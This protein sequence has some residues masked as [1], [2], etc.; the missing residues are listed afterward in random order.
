MEE[1]ISGKVVDIRYTSFD[2]EYTVATVRL[3]DKS[4]VVVTGP[5]A[6]VDI[7]D[8][9]EI[10]GEYVTH[11]IY[12]EQ[13]KVNSFIPLKP[14]D[15]QGIY[16]FLASGVIEGIGEKFA[17][18]IMQVFGDK[19]L[20][21]IE[22][23]PERL[24]EIEGIGSKKLDK[25]ITSYNEKMMLKNIII[26][27]AKYD[28]S[29]SLSIK[30]YNAYNENTLKILSNN[31]YR[32]C[33]DIKGIGFKKADEIAK[34]MGVAL[35]ST[36]R[37][38]QA[39]IYSLTQSTYEG[40]T[41]TTFFKLKSDMKELIDFDDED[42]ILS[43]SYDLYAKKQIIIDGIEKDDMKIF[44][45]RYALAET[46]VASKLIEL[47]T[48]QDK[49][50]DEKKLDEL[51]QEQ[52]KYSNIDFSQE[53]IKSVKMAVN[54]N[55]LIITGGPGTGKT[56]TLSFIIEI[57]ERIGKK[58]KLCAPTGKAS[59]RMA[60]ATN[61]DASTIHRLL[62]MNY[63][64]DDMQEHFL[65][66]EDE[67]IKADVIIVD[68]TS[69]V[70]I[71]LMQSLLLAI[72]NGT[73]LILVGDKDQ[74]PS[75]GAGNVLKDIINCEIIPCI[76]LNKI[77][78]QAMKSHIIV[79]AHR[80]NEGKMPLTN[81]KDND[82][83]IM[84]RNDKNS[85]EKLIVELITQ[86]LPKYYDITPKDIQII[87]PMKKREIGTQNLNKLLQE[88]LNPKDPVKNEYKT[89]FKIYRE[90]DRVIHIKNNYEKQW[91]SDKEEG[92][93]VFNGD[94]GTI[95]SVNLREKFLTVNFDDGKKA[96]YDFDELDELEHSF[97]LTVHKSQGSE[98]PCVILPIHSVA[99][100][101]MTRKI[102]YT[103]ITRAKKLLII[104]S[105]NSNIKK[106]VDNIYEEER[107]STL[108]QKLKMFKDY[109]MLD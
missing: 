92:S 30:I 11:R 102:L 96:T 109:K 22:K 20:D 44:L 35:D 41:Y 17:R 40:H 70:D 78:R 39:I 85:I 10:T 29:T 71:L 51:I 89:Q 50:I 52:I 83:F 74:L 32:L 62:E 104:I 42:E 82:F 8:N 27:L 15:E 81:D 87:T 36:E 63:S 107:N 49:K 53:Q 25:I 34:K 3:G 105:S 1:K 97:A 28:L 103:A 57:F 12:G 18:R 37:K 67:P 19:T 33:D 80:I 84:N 47:A 4:E 90:N 99:P 68:E 55:I 95:E 91:I 46:T 65:K 100:M 7:G 88:A 101:L 16:E 38:I 108:M 86:R 93:G 76:K 23:A 75:V 9:I 21:I 5:I 77:F 61:K 13:F 72:K 94:T 14:D 58:V 26:Q 48:Y 6:A 45:Y 64:S 69:M 2:G 73:H 106:M 54:N 59:K 31:P 43:I 66:N 60:Q 98:Y 24:L 79:N 56:T